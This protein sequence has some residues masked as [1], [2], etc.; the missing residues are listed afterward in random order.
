MSNLTKGLIL[1]FVI[2]AIG[3]GLVVWK[4]KVGGQAHESFNSISREEIEMLLADVS[5]SNPAILK[6]LAEDPEMKKQQIDNLKQLLAFAS[7]A[8]K[9]GMTADLTNSQE[10][11]NIK[12]EISAVNY[13]REMNKD[14]GSMPPFGFIT[15]D[16][17]NQYW[18]Q[19]SEPAAGKGWFAT[20]M[21]KLGLGGE[22]AE[23][24]THEAE[25]QDFLNAKIALLKASSPEMKDREISEEEKTQAKDVFAKIRI[26]KKE[27]ETKAAAGELPKEFIAKV[28]LQVKLQQAQFLA[29]IYSEKIGD[30]MKVTDEEITQYVAAHPELDPK[31]KRA[32]AQGILDRAKAGEDFA[33]LAN[34]FTE[35][36]GN[37]G[38]DGAGQGGIYKD[39]TKG[40][41]VA[42]FEAAALAL[43]P[44]QISPELVETDFGFHIIKLERALSAGAAP[45][46]PS[47]AGAPGATGETYDARHILISTS[48]KDPDKPQAREMPVKEYVRGKLEE[49]KE[50]KMLDEIVAANNIQVPADFTV[51]AVS[52]QQMQEMQQKQQQMQM[53]QQGMPPGGPGGPGGPGAPPPPGAPKPGKPEPKKP[54]PKK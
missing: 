6:K 21:D 35:D 47:P 4:K 36:P 50:K 37:K 34:E 7:Q 14:K 40:K 28:N 29:R 39:I 44:G 38:P 19:A 42:P 26:Y 52:E 22:A 27:Y 2:V 1:V 16:M 15:E 51:P 24:R 23:T 30:K 46:A 54:E 31:E 17:V 12:A 49:E 9:E 13:D 20:Q 18:G 45:K 11:Q 25:F 8:Q 43:Q 3:A 53:Q 48:F 33:K 41:M 10:L 5:K 32:K